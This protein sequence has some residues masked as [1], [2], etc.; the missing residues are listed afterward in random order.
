MKLSAYVLLL[1]AVVAVSGIYSASAA[2]INTSCKKFGFDLYMVKVHGQGA[3]NFGPE[4]QKYFDPSSFVC[5][6]TQIPPTGELCL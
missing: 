4:V 2:A 6:N 5:Q 1:V 3:E